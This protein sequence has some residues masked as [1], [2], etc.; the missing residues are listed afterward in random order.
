MPT[1]IAVIKNLNNI[2]VSECVEK[3]EPHILQVV[4]NSFLN[5]SQSVKM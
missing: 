3:L 4:M 2:S 5:V 1:R